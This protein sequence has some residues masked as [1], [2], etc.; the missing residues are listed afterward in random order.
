[1]G[2]RTS[3]TTPPAKTRPIAVQLPIHMVKQL[4]QLA[5]K[6]GLTRH[7]YMIRVLKDAVVK[8]VVVRESVNFS[9]DPGPEIT[10]KTP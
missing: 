5:A 1:M 8:D 4:D 9:N 10:D 7:K 3:P 2:R 6:S